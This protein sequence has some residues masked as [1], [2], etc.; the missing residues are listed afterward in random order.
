MPHDDH[1]RH[2]LATTLTRATMDNQSISTP[3]SENCDRAS[4]LR[5]PIMALPNEFFT[6]SFLFVP[7]HYLIAAKVNLILRQSSP[8]TSPSPNRVTDALKAATKAFRSFTLTIRRCR[9]CLLPTLYIIRLSNGSISFPSPIPPPPTA[10]VFI[11]DNSLPANH[12]NET[13]LSSSTLPQQADTKPDPTKA[14][15]PNPITRQSRDNGRQPFLRN[16][17]WHRLLAIRLAQRQWQ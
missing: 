7:H 3:F 12:T 15:S 16:P 8:R 9:H 6:K 11:K 17:P 14:S 2:Q 5:L 10:L 4:M 1:E 13:I